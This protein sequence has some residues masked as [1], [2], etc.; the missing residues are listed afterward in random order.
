M[1]R[2]SVP[3]GNIPTATVKVEPSTVTSIV[4]GPLFSHP[5]SASHNGSQG[6]ASLQTSSPSST[7]QEMIT[8][9]DNSQEFKP[10]LNA[11]SHSARPL[12]SAAANVSILNNL[13]QARQVMSSASLTGGTSSMGIQT[14][15]GTPMAM[16][17]S[18][19]ISNGA[20][21]NSFSSGQ[22]GIA[23][24]VGTSQNAQN[25]VLGSFSTQA[26]NI[27][28]NSNNGMSPPLV[29]V[30]A[31]V[32]T[33]QS[34][35]A[36]SPGNLSGTQIGTN[37]N[38]NILNGS[39]GISSGAGT[40]MPTPGISQ[41]VA[42]G[43]QSVGATNSSTANMS[44]AASQSSPAKYVR[45]W[46]IKIRNR[47]MNYCHIYHLNCMKAVYQND[48]SCVQGGLSGKRQGLPVFITKLEGYRSASASET[49]AADWPPMMQIVRLISQDHMNNK[50]YDGKADFLVFKALDQHGFLGQLQEKKLCAV[51]QLPSQ[52]L[53]LSVSDKASRL[54]GML[55]PGVRLWS[56]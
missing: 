18:N 11:M 13:S 53:L 37:M 48:A 30:Q 14:I 56:N 22:S 55:F 29:N 31:A 2:Q 32:T 23:S 4:Q 40:M 15:N 41:Q 35:P 54:I 8:N 46:E 9:G 34:V 51:I 21:Q 38:Q 28:G 43:M 17:M 27:S 45:V 1:N 24:L 25:A 6:A 44:A 3:V 19:M 50:H 7:S 20:A 26:S 42:A 12:G 16:H 33:G 49:L 39:S 5:P 52:T 36:I 10:I 47:N